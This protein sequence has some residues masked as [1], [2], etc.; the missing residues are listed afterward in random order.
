MAGEMDTT[1]EMKA[2]PSG[3]EIKIVQSGIP[4]AIPVDGCYL[5]WQD[6]LVKLAMLVEP[7]I[8]EG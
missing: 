5:G 3:T 1:V 4:D 6:S 7:E 2:V 8:P